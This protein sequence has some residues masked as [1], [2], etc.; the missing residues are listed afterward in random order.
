MFRLANHLILQI[1]HYANHQR[2][3]AWPTS[4]A[5]I[6]LLTSSDRK[7]GRGSVNVLA[8]A[9]M[10]MVRAQ[11]IELLTPC[12]CKKLHILLRRKRGEPSKPALY[13]TLRLHVEE[14]RQ[15]TAPLPCA[16]ARTPDP[17]PA[18][19][20]HEHRKESFGDLHSLPRQ[21]SVD[22]IRGAGLLLPRREI[23]QS[24]C[25]RPA[26]PQSCLSWH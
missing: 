6:P 15:D 23:G 2:F 4:L 21:V 17:N 14:I 1:Y 25:P 24:P 5:A 16:A 19:S 7:M 22:G 9:P 18:L 13:S 26:R 3:E 8:G 12:R 10:S 11:A 20:F